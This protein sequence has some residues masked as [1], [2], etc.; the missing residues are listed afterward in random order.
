M[1]FSRRDLLAGLLTTAPLFA[2]KP[3][4]EIALAGGKIYP[5]PHQPSIPEGV[6]ILRDGFVAAVGPVNKTH[7]PSKALVV[8]CRGAFVLPGFTNASV[9]LSG[10]QWTPA[11][12]LPAAAL[13]DHMEATLNRWGFSFAYDMAVTPNTA[14]LIRRIEANHL[15]GPTIRRA[16]RD[17]DADA[18][19]LSLSDPIEKIRTTTAEAHRRQKLAFARPTSRQ[20]ALNAV[21]GG[22]DV[23][24]HPPPRSFSFEPQL[25]REMIDR[26]VAF[27]PALHLYELEAQTLGLDAEESQ[28]WVLTAQDQVRAFA[29]A[30]GQILFGT[31]IGTGSDCNPTRE[32]LL[33]AES[34]LLPMQILATLTTAPSGRFAESRVRGQ[35]APGFVADVTV[36]QA[37]PAEDVR[38]FAAVRLNLRNGRVLFRTT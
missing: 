25:L 26:K 18:L 27:V 24:I 9:D 5:S 30:G 28:A 35:L 37:D 14:D 20:E 11:A 17:A 21:L 12:K 10:R 15:P 16:A 23:L 4:A 31:N 32:Y 22:A 2:A 3:H 7:I 19:L 8:D 34:G 1:P 36:L 33:L 29:A 13:A 6:V 38:N